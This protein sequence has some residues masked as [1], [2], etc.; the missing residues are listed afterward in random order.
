MA[1]SNNVAS[2]FLL[3]DEGG[4]GSDMLQAKVKHLARGRLQRD[5]LGEGL[6]LADWLATVGTWWEI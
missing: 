4:D 2:S 1:S 5:P 6:N 3:V